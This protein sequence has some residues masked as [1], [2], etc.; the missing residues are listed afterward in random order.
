MTTLRVEVG[1]A[2]ST[3]IED[4][5]RGLRLAGCMRSIEI[6]PTGVQFL[7]IDD[8]RKA[9]E[10][11]GFDVDLVAWPE[12]PPLP[13]WRRV[14]GWPGRV[15]RWGRRVVLGETF[16]EQFISDLFESYDADT[17][18]KIATRESPFLR[19]VGKVYSADEREGIKAEFARWRK[20]G[21]P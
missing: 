20:D 19:K 12:P 16:E 2:C 7:P 4:V 10:N 18:H 17:I 9:L 14:R 21:E 13:W 6:D 11:D 3:T 8:V 1:R 5:V 15:Y